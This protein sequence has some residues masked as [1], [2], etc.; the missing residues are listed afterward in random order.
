MTTK[1]QKIERVE[2]KKIYVA[3]DGTEFEDVNECK[4]Y[5][6]TA[7]CAIDAMFNKLKMQK[8]EYVGD[9]IRSF[10]MDDTVYAIKIKNMNQL[11]VVNKWIKSREA[12]GRIIGEDEVGTI[13]LICDDGYS[14]WTMGTPDNLKKEYCDAIDGFFDEL[15]GNPE[16]VKGEK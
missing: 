6:Q 2:I 5:E 12:S 9:S 13:Q 7:K 1:E 11:E 8:T 14:A 15:I 10:C 3:N 16:E 4:K